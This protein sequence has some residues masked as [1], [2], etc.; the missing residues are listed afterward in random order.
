MNLREK[1]I[2][3]IVLF[4]ADLVNGCSLPIPCGTEL[5]SMELT[6]ITGIV[7]VTS[8][9][10]EEC[11]FDSNKFDY[12]LLYETKTEFDFNSGV[13]RKDFEAFIASP[14]TEEV[15]LYKQETV[16]QEGYS[17]A[18]EEYSDK[19]FVTGEKFGSLNFTY[20]LSG[21]IA[22]SE[23][24]MYEG[25]ISFYSEKMKRIYFI[26]PGQGFKSAIASCTFD[27]DYFCDYS[28]T[29]ISFSSINKSPILR[30]NVYDS[31]DLVALPLV[32]CLCRDYSYFMFN[33]TT[34]VKAVDILDTRLNELDFR[35]GVAYS[36]NIIEEGVSV[37]SEHIFQEIQTEI[38]DMTNMSISGMTNMS[39]SGMTNMGISGSSFTVTNARYS[40]LKMICH[41][42]GGIG[43]FL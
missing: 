26:Y 22:P 9:V 7:H 16:N 30:A 10:Y 1:S 29:D 34:V 20:T 37:V 4:W 28:S 11:D 31:M 38:I 15:G 40:W 13:E 6:N 21:F 19:V 14:T 5:K 24:G 12:R 2:V 17:L 23:S 8:S 43:F 25:L 33:M 3:S 27:A 18:Y 35:I 36:A 32:C 41:I 42:L 39:I